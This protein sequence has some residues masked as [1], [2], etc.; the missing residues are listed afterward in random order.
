M[1]VLQLNGENLQLN[2]LDLYLNGTNDAA[3]VDSVVVSDGLITTDDVGGT[4]TVTVTFSEAMDTDFTPTITFSPTIA[5]TL[6]FD[7][8]AWSGGDTIYTASYDIANGD[9]EVNGVSIDVTG[10]VDAGDSASQEDYT[11][12]PQF[13]INTVSTATEGGG[14]DAGGGGQG[15]SFTRER[16]NQLKKAILEAEERA[17]ELKKKS[18]ERVETAIEAAT[19]VADVIEASDTAIDDYRVDELITLLEGVASANTAAQAVKRANEA[20]KAAQ[21]ALAEAEEEEEAIMLLMLH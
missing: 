21:L 20:L 6:T 8:G 3:T 17:E 16:W 4:F 13:S 1:P 2:G 11:P 19:A 12:V 5:S 14:I 15:H 9:I 10:A 7:S 18:Q